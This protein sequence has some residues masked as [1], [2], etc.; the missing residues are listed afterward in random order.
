[1][2][3]ELADPESVWGK[4]AAEG[5]PEKTK[6]WLAENAA[7]AEKNIDTALAAQRAAKTGARDASGRFTAREARENAARELHDLTG[8]SPDATEAEV[9]HVAAQRAGMELDRQGRV[10]PGMALDP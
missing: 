4:V 9:R 3:I 6:A 5:V 2:R 8:L 1:V 10:V 7:N